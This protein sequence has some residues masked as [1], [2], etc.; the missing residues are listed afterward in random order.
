KLRQSLFT[1]ATLAVLVLA[2]V[3]WLGILSPTGT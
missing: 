1:E 3:A 2:S